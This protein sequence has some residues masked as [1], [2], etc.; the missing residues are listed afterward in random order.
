MESLIAKW[1]SSSSRNVALISATR[2]KQS[3]L[4]YLEDVDIQYLCLYYYNTSLEFY[5]F[6]KSKQL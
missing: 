3:S 1:D 2:K 6:L 4:S 5:S